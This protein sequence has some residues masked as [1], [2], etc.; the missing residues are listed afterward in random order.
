[1]K[2]YLVTGGAGFIG[3]NLIERLLNGDSKVIC[4]DNFTLGKKENVDIFLNNRNFYFYETDLSVAENIID[5]AVRHQIDY[6]FHL[7]ANSD[8]QLSGQGP[9]MDH[10]N[11]FLTTLAVLECMRRKNIKKLFFSSS[12]AV[13]GER[14]G[15][16]L[17][18]ETPLQPI[19]YY[20]GAK[21]A[22]ESF[23]QAYSAMN[24]FDVTIF[25]FPNVIGP[26][27]THGVIFDFIKKLRK[28]HETLEILGD[29][30]QKKSYIY[31][32]DLIDA[33]LPIA[34]GDDRDVNIYNIAA[35]EAT[36]VKEIADMVCAKMNLK[37]VQYRYSGGDRGWKGDIPTFKFDTSKI[38]GKGWIAKYTSTQAVEATLNAVFK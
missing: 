24:G 34:L 23:I 12:G 4:A 16:L 17:T 28:N 7:A 3:Y 26:H 36:T 33:I 30:T 9:L 11:T 31:V 19:S 20:G 6:I 13:Y 32:E 25:R 29:G 2:T 1:V 27:L 21:M 14:P 22:S 38:V 37:N 18:E 8:I 35:E 15:I 5:I 10:E